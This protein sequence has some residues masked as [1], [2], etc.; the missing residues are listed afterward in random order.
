ME[1]ENRTLTSGIQ[2]FRQSI[3]K[4]DYKALGAKGMYLTVPYRLRFVRE[5]FGDRLSIQTESIELTN[6]SH[7]FKA[8]IFLDSKLLSVGESKQMHNKEKDFEKQQTVS[9]GRGLSILGF[10]GDEI[11]S[12]EEIEQFLRN[13]PPAKPSVVKNFPKEKTLVNARVEE[14]ANDWISQLNTVASLSKSQNDFEK[15]LMPIRKEYIDDLQAITLDPVQY[16]RVEE[17]YNKL[18]KQIQNNQTKRKT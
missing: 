11:A 6:G 18:K 17:E 16:L 15:Q 13:D 7:K 10:F 2:A 9:I 5:Y 8:F 4:D 3:K 12:Y 1:K 14:M